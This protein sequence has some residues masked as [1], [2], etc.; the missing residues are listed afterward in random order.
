MNVVKGEFYYALGS[1][2]FGK[3]VGFLKSVPKGQISGDFLEKYED[4]QCIVFAMA[5]KIGEEDKSQDY[6]VIKKNDFEKSQG[7][8][9]PKIQYFHFLHHGFEKLVQ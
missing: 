4:G 9:A 6:N 8:P 3:V 7:P 5:K 2:E 1:D